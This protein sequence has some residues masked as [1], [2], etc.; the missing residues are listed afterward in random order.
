MHRIIHDNLNAFGGSERLVAT[1]IQCLTENGFNVD[2]ATFEMPDIMK[3]Q[4]LFGIDLNNRIRKILFSNLHSI[5]NMD[6]QLINNNIDGYDLVI[7]T[8]GDL[9]PFYEK[10][11]VML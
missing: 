10:I 9:L 7:N 2:L 1:S 5:L 3:I 6:E 11:N 8:H 4:K